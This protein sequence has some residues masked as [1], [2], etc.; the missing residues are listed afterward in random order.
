MTVERSL[1]WNSD[2][3]ALRFA[4]E[5]PAALCTIV[6]ID[7]SY[8][9][10]LGGQLAIGHD[11]LIAGSLA[12]GCLERELETQSKLAWIAGEPLVLRFGKDSP[13]IDFRLPCGSGLDILID[14]QPD[15]TALQ[16]TVAALERRSQASLSLPVPKPGMLAMR[17]YLPA[18]RLLVLGDSAD[19][20]AL[21]K[22]ASA[23]GTQCIEV[24]PGGGGIALGKVP[25]NLSADPWTA[26]VL[27]FHNHE[28]EAPILEWALASPAFYVGAIG[29]K[30]AR[31]SRVTQLIAR[32]YSRSSVAKLRS[33]I[34]LIP[35]AREADTLALGVLAEIVREYES[36]R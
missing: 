7:G 10:R 31:E 13:F 12:D 30:A 33:P 29:G 14:P 22:L 18:L 23:F 20:S 5:R 26:V 34:G 27:L 21:A 1:H 24:R 3:A 32:G 35:A 28:W 16:E 2:Q 6:G 4:A 15:R 9:R 17:G 19:A 25:T 11:G 36:L 8:S